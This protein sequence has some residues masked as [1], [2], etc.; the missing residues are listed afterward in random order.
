M[1][2][3]DVVDIL[4]DRVHHYL[5]AAVDLRARQHDVEEVEV[6]V[7]GGQPQLVDLPG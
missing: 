7:G 5:L 6:D 1:A 4:R 3:V 2:L